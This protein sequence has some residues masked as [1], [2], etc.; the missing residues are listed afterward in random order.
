MVYIITFIASLLSELGYFKLAK[1]FGIVDRPNER[2]SHKR[3]T[4]RGGGI[5]FFFGII[6]YSLLF[7]FHY[8][9]CFAG[10]LI[11]AVI[12]FLDDIMTVR[13]RYRIVFHFL[14]MLLMFA[15]CG[16]YD[17]PWYFSLIA[18]VVATGILNAYNFMDGI[19]GMTG[20]YSM[21]VIA[22]F[23]YI[24]NYI[25]PFTDNN[26]LYVICISLLIF[27]FFNFRKRAKCFAG[28]V[29]SFSIAFLTV[30]LLGKLIIITHDVTYIIVL[31]LYGI[32]TILTIVHRLMLREYIFEAHRK[33]MYQIMSNELHIPHIYVSM[34]Y[35]AVQ[36]IIMIGYFAFKEYSMWYFFISA[37]TMAI[38]YITFMSKY[39]KLHQ[40]QS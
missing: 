11:I 5:I 2:S 34:T 10:F 36:T 9:L 14:A 23:W 15:D 32:D 39:F 6:I 29:G 1:H 18:L 31:M 28:D 3:V 12:S 37:I 30:F 22:S 40:V 35:M 21:V 13:A 27:N 20:G 25:Q 4:L 26:L 33:H 8:P 38:I 16:F 19:N 7:G 24:N 17:I